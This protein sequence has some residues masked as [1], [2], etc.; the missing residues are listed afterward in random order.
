MVCMSTR[1]YSLIT[2]STPKGPQLLNQLVGSD[3]KYRHVQDIGFNYV[4]D[5]IDRLWLTQRAVLLA[6]SR[7]TDGFFTYRLA[8]LEGC[9]D[10]QL[11]VSQK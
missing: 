8:N 7:L 3:V 1:M 2:S 9:L 5:C 10:S 4:F 6:C 11:A